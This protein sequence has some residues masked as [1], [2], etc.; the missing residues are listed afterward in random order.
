MVFDDSVDRG[1]QV[2]AKQADKVVDG[3]AAKDINAQLRLYLTALAYGA[4]ALSLVADVVDR[5]IDVHAFSYLVA[6]STK[7][8]T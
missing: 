3:H 4:Q 6:D 2:A 1:G 7:V 8:D 5:V